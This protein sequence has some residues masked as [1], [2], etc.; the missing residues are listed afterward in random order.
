LHEF[1]FSDEFLLNLLETVPKNFIY[2]WFFKNSEFSSD[3]LSGRFSLKAALQ[4]DEQ[5]FHLLLNSFFEKFQRWDVKSPLFAEGVKVEIF[6]RFQKIPTVAQRDNLEIFFKIL[7]CDL[8][9]YEFVLFSKMNQISNGERISRLA[10]LQKLLN[11]L[12]DFPALLD[13]RIKSFVEFCITENVHWDSMALDKTKEIEMFLDERAQI[14]KSSKG[15]MFETCVDHIIKEQFAESPEIIDFYVL[16]E[17]KKAELEVARE[18]KRFFAS[19]F[20]INNI[21]ISMDQLS[22]LL[23]TSEFITWLS[24]FFF[25]RGFFIHF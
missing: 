8:L 4:E 24:G 18:L 19:A 7:R 2:S 21:I 20:N 10:E 9:F 12:S 13:A 25:S 22:S 6:K 23:S 15:N 14:L 11:E 3:V 5:K 1:V 17:L 16:L